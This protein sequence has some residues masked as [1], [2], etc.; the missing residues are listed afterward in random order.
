MR[1]ILWIPV[2]C[3]LLFSTATYAA[4]PTI[5]DLIAAVKSSDQPARLIAMDS[6]GLMGE[7]AA[8]AVPAV[9]AA[10]KDPSAV[11]RSHAAQAFG[12]IGAPAKSAVPDLAALIDD[13]RP[14]VRREAIL[15]LA[16]IGDAATPAIPRILRALDDPPAKTAAIYAL[17]QLRKAGGKAEAKIR[18]NVDSSDQVL[19]AVSLWA[20]GRL[21]PDDKKLLAQTTERLC[22]TLKSEN[23]R[24]RKAAARAL[25]SLKPGPT[26]CYRP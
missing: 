24:A 14:E 15:A 6:L 2:F 26:L 9:A 4:E 13:P 17:G 7:K 3:G 12:A 1:T 20:L 25:A 19:D 23:P 18:Q 11:V 16:E 8:A 10:L 22:E 5:S 21:H